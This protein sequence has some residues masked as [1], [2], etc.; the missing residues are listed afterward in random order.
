MR[1]TPRDRRLLLKLAAARWLSTKQVAALLFSNVTPEMARRRLRL[2]NE[3][4]YV[5][6]WQHNSMAE[7]LH[8]LDAKGKDFL[9]EKGW[10]FPVKLERVPPKNLEHFIGINDIR[11]AVERSAQ[12]DEHHIGF[13]YACWELQQRGWAHAL[14]PD[15]A[16]HVERR[17]ASMTVL[18]EYDRG[19]ETAEYVSRTKLVPYMHGLDG[20]SFS[21]VVFIAESEDRLEQLC[22]RARRIDDNGKFVFVLRATVMQPSWSIAQWF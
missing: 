18:L 2:L 20:L 8:A 6:S 1:L 11:V 12:S 4:R 22:E 15:A 17:G 5:F 3:D 7:A 9:K 10:G 21:M 13:F 19:Q 16:C 14:I